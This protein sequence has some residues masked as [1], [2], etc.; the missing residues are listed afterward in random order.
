V[1]SEPDIDTA[2]ATSPDI[3]A[4]PPKP[5]LTRV[6][7]DGY[8]E[9]KR[10][11]TSAGLLE[12]RRRSY[13]MDAIILALAAATVVGGMLLTAG[14]WWILSLT[15][16]AAVVFGQL[17]FLAHDAAHNQILESSRGN[18]TLSVLLFNLT[19]GGSRGWWAY[20]HNLHHAQPNRLG[21]DPDISGGVIAISEDEAMAAGGFTRAMMRRQATAIWPLLTLGVLQIHVYSAAFLLSR[22]LR[23][24]GLEASLFVAHYVVYLGG[25]TA[26]LGPL[27]GLLFALMHQMLLGVYLGGAFLPNHIGMAMLEREESMTFLRRQVLT[28]R[29]LR[30]G[31]VLD[32]VFGM[33]SCQIEHHLFPTM[34]RCHLRAAAPMVRRFCLERG[35]AYHETGV[36]AAFGEVRRHLGV[37]VACLHRGG[38]ADRA[39]L[40]R[41]DSAY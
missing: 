19:L 4:A 7:D 5:A 24:G 36:L 17:G 31:R 22:R 8:A 40:G 27:R 33:L 37:V 39:A 29:N 20:K 9:L 32:R 1:H 21:V 11:V 30:T 38:S 34:P 12:R 23:R 28:G 10:L 16:P 13:L 6:S 18:Y 41:S 26:L 25:L 15:V 14:S 2:L 3:V 35:I